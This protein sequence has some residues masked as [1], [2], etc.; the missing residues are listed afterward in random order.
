MNSAQY[1]V[2]GDVQGDWERLLE[3]LEPYGADEHQTVFLGDFFQGGRPGDMGG[4][5]CARIARE[6]AHSQ[7]VLGNHE[8]FILAVLELLRGVPLPPAFGEEPGMGARFREYLAE[9]D[10]FIRFWEFRRGDWEDVHALQADND[11][12]QWIRSRPIMLQLEDGTLVQHTDTDVY[13]SHGTTLDEVNA[14]GRSCLDRDGGVFELLP[15]ISKRHAFDDPD[16]TKE[17]LAAFDA[18]RIVHGHT[19]CGAGDAPAVRWNGKAL[20][21][22][23]R[24]SRYWRR[25]DEEQEA[26]PVEA[27]VGLLPPLQTL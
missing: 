19:P 3:A 16:R 13:L 2:V 27:T 22:D 14:W 9:E 17:Y 15:S 10:G 23:G 26:G 21:Y 11:L 6:R 5:R 18:P 7:V 8:V 4:V 1:L 25:S 12:E 24:F 20:C